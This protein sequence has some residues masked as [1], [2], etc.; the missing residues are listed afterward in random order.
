M[1]TQLNTQPNRQQRR[2]AA[3]AKRSLARTPRWVADPMA[4]LNVADQNTPLTAGEIETL[5]ASVWQSIAAFASGKAT[6]AHWRQLVDA[7]NLCEV[8][9]DMGIKD[10]DPIEAAT[11]TQTIQSANNALAA[12]L[13]RYNAG[14]RLGFDGTGLQAARA[15]GLVH[16]AMLQQCTRGAWIKALNTLSKKVSATPPHLRVAFDTDERAAA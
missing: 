6:S 1:N 12:A 8:F 15:M 5:D 7:C 2:Q 13:A 11:N 16:N 14:H 10:A 9:D 3:R 4:A